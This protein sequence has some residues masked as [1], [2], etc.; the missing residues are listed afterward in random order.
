[1]SEFVVSREKP[2]NRPLYD[3]FAVSN[4]QGQLSA[5]HYTAYTLNRGKWYIFN[6]HKVRQCSE[7]DHIVSSAAYILFYKRRGMN[8]ENIDYEQIR[9]RLDSAENNSS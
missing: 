9:N 5:G 4:H 6:D 3:L 8:F 7:Q 2:P 1:M